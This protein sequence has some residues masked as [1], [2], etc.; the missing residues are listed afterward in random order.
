[1]KKL[2]KIHLEDIL[3]TYLRRRGGRGGDGETRRQ[4]E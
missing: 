1:M 4:G 2:R 3:L